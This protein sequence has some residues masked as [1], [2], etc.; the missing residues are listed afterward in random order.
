MHLTIQDI[1][2]TYLLN[3]GNRK[4]EFTP[5]LKRP[6]A[7]TDTSNVFSVCG[8]HSVEDDMSVAASRATIA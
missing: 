3:Y 5:C 4:N 7:M 2:C 1:V 6:G 8:M